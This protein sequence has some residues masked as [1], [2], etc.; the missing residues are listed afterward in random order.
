[1]VPELPEQ[2]VEA[3][4]LVIEPAGTRGRFRRTKV[5]GEG[6]LW[7]RC[8]RRDWDPVRRGVIHGWAGGRAAG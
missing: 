3:L 5:P 4:E 8:W 7:R 6:R 2:G 1:V